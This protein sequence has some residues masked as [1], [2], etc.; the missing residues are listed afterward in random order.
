MRVAMIGAGYV[1][2]TTGACLAQ[3]GHTVTCIDIDERKIADLRE[4]IIPIYEPGLDE[5]VQSNSQ[6]NRLQFSF[7]LASSVATADAVFLAVGT[8]SRPGGA[9]DLSFVE[10]AAREIAP[11]IPGDCVVVVKSTVVAGTAKRLREIIAEARGG[12]DFSV[13][14][15]PE[16]LREGSAVSDFLNPDRIVVGTDDR[17]AASVMRSLYAPLLE[18]GVPCVFT[19]TT[20][21]EMIK[22]A[23]NAFLALKI[24][25]I[26]EVADLCEQIGGDVKAVA[27]GIGLDRRI[28]SA[29]LAAGPGFGGSCFPK[30]TRAFAAI[31]RKVGA[32]QTLVETLIERNEK[33]KANVGRR[34]LEELGAVAPGAHVAV[35]GVA[36]KAN[37]DDVREAAALSII[38]LLQEAG[39]IVHAYDP[40][41]DAAALLPGVSWH[42]SAYEAARGA[43]LTVVLTEWDEFRSLDLRKLAATMTGETLFDC[44]NLFEPAAVG[45]AGLRY[46]AIGRTPAD[47]RRPP[48]RPGRASTVTGARVVASPS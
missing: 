22:Y 4:G 26:N 32:P 1:G 47:Q 19:T 24:G 46:V 11:A 29:F 8:P 2:L 48:R 33:R 44:R 34:I 23:A 9:I 16:F 45:E 42:A 31:G 7:E 3:L 12:L 41:A 38:P 43:D 27:E 36:F 14:S 39:C 37:T 20:N 25:F 10:A 35:L 18:Q 40:E 13:A 28:G 17:R 6:L 15:N 30:D 21:A 5:L